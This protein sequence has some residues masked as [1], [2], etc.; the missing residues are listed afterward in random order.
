M[1]SRGKRPL[2]NSPMPKSTLL[3]LGAAGNLL[4]AFLAFRTGRIF[5][6]VVLV[7][8]AFCFLAAALGGRR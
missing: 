5:I 2:A 6:A 4:I 7:A 3:I 1:R 8:A